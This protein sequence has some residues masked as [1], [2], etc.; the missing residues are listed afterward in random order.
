MFMTVLD[1]KQ[2]LETLF[3]LHSVER[4]FSTKTMGKYIGVHLLHSLCNTTIIT[5]PGMFHHSAPHFNTCK[6]MF[7]LHSPLK[8]HLCRRSS[9]N[10][11]YQ[12]NKTFCLYFFFKNHGR[13]TN[14]DKKSNFKGVEHFK[15]QRNFKCTINK[16]TVYLV[17]SL[18]YVIL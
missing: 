9:C 4:K 13:V 10:H 17:V 18:K 2:S 11:Y 1:F 5:N 15:I 3:L 7:S 12:V 14:D 16:S 8:L 6:C